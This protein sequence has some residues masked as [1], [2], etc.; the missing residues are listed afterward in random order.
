M[1]SN[2][3]VGRGGKDSCSF[4]QFLF[5][6]FLTSFLYFLSVSQTSL[7]QAQ[8]IECVTSSFLLLVAMPGASS[9]SF[10]GKMFVIAS[11]YY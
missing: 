8:S 4:Y 5:Q 1:S 2:H 6:S 11:C 10:L 7:N 3:L 9:F